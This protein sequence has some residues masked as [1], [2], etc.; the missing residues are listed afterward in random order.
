MSAADY[1]K[2][3]T[4]SRRNDPHENPW[5]DG[6]DALRDLEE[7]EATLREIGAELE[8]DFFDIS[9]TARIGAKSP[10]Q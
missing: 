10:S 3:L 6:F 2:E 1:I 4:A 8:P 7:V 5:R 9:L